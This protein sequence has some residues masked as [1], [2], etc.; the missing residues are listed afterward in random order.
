[1]NPGVSDVVFDNTSWL[2]YICDVYGIE[3]WTRR[4]AAANSISVLL[5]TE[6]MERGEPM[7][8]ITL[9]D[10]VHDSEGEGEECEGQGVL[11]P[12]GLPEHEEELG[13]AIRQLAPSLDRRNQANR[14]LATIREKARRR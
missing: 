10:F 9:P 5:D 3:P 8:P 7:A 11:G 12:P 1:M 14:L 4:I 6:R 2:K 13:A